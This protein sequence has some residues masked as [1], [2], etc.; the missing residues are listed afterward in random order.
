MPLTVSSHN[1]QCAYRVIKPIGAG[2]G[3]MNDGIHV[4][5]HKRTGEILVEKKIKPS[6]LDFGRREI[7][8]LRGLEPHEGI[9]RCYEAFLT[10][11]PPTAALYLEWCDLGNLLC[12]IERFALRRLHIP[13]QF[14]WHTFHALAN[15]L[16]YLHFGTTASSPSTAQN[17]PTVLHRDIKPNN[18]FLKSRATN[19]NII[20]PHIVLG[21][22]GL[23]TR[24]GMHDFPDAGAIIGTARWQ[25]P[26]IPHHSCRGEVWSVGAVIHSMCHLDEGPVSQQP[27][28]GIEE[29]VWSELPIARRPRGLDHTLYSRE[30]GSVMSKCLRYVKEDRPM[31]GEL[32]LLVQ[33]MMARAERPFVPLPAWAFDQ[34]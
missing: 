1:L 10:T 11:N 22:F 15:T 12:L 21:D 20:Y 6:D 16:S 26:Q 14:I 4:V 5:R 23:S 29:R 34:N 9:V 28:H 18:I 7:E 27:P 3:R 31:A 17:W 19:A 25:P 30:L 8:I 33:Q 24:L 13:E 2:E 32:A